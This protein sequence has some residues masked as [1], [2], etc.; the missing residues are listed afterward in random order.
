MLK[1]IEQVQSLFPARCEQCVEDQ[2]HSLADLF[3]WIT[4]MVQCPVSF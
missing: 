2:G 4:C 1:T 3:S